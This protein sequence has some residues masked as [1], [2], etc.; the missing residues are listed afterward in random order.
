MIYPGPAKAKSRESISLTELERHEM[1]FMS[2]SEK[3]AATG[4]G[5]IAR[6]L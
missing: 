4:G 3:A 6:V 2:N 1:L 5:I